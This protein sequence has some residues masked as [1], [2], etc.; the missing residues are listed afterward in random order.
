MKKIYK[1]FYEIGEN[2]IPFFAGAL[3]T[4]VGYVLCILFV[5]ILRR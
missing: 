1:F 5:L 3:S 4:L 2:P